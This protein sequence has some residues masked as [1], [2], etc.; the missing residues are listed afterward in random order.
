MKD[1]LTVPITAPQALKMHPALSSTATTLCPFRMAVMHVVGYQQGP[2]EGF[3]R[4]VLFCLLCREALSCQG[5]VLCNYHL[6]AF[7][8]V[9]L[10]C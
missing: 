3:S 10:S 1:V 2:R 4:C 9:L 5:S 7:T 6:S 8:C